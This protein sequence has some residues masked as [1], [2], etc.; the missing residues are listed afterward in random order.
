M[1]PAPKGCAPDRSDREQFK[2]D[3]ARNALKIP[4]IRA[5]SARPMPDQLDASSHPDDGI[6]VALFSQPRGVR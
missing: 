6:E 1:D 4:L 2:S 3:G 5:T